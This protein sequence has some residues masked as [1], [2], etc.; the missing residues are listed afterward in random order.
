[1]FA[2]VPAL[3]GGLVLWT[4]AEYLLHRF[5]MHARGGW[6]IGREHRLHHRE[7]LRTNIVLRGA[8]YLGLAV[9]GLLGGATLLPVSAFAALGLAAGWTAGYIGY[10]Q[11]HWNSHHRAP[12]TRFG[13]R[14]RHVHLHHH[15][16]R[17]QRNHGV[18]SSLWDRVFQTF[19]EPGLV[20]VPK[21]DPPPWLETDPDRYCEQLRVRG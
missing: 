6:V 19:E 16:V 10:E 17:P 1:M 4:L 21:A 8:G 15:F 5:V 20:R 3:V 13:L 12:R 2:F 7:P 9:I 18:S 11:I 14:R